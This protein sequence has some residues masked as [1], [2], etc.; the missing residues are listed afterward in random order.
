MIMIII[1]LIII[2]MTYRKTGIDAVLSVLVECN[3]LGHKDGQLVLQLAA[4][5]S[6]LLPYRRLAPLPVRG[7]NL[8][9]SGSRRSTTAKDPLPLVR[10]MNGIDAVLR[11]NTHTQHNNRTSSPQTDHQ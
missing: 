6:A 10:L 5:K 7:R 9:K 1:I 4:R 11:E 2:H 8:T 3:F